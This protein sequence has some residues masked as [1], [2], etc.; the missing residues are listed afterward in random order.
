MSRFGLGV[1]STIVTEDLDL[2][3]FVWGEE[4]LDLVVL[5]FVLDLGLLG[6]NGTVDFLEKHGYNVFGPNKKCSQIEGSK[7]YSKELLNNLIYLYTRW[8]YN[9]ILNHMRLN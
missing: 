3:G 8:E 6:P 1:G 2:K 4:T 9:Q 5:F 7:A